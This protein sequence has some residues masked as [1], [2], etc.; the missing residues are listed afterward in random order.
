[1][2]QDLVNASIVHVDGTTVL[3]FT[4]ARSFLTQFAN[5]GTGVNFIYSHG[6][7]DTST[8]FGYHGSR[9]GKVFISDFIDGSSITPVQP[10]LP[11]AVAASAKSV[12]WIPKTGSLLT[13]SYI[14]GTN[15]VFVEFSVELQ[16]WTRAPPI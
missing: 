9:R 3:S 15:D 2:G 1:M 6:E 8:S 16:V 5:G 11:P 12:K 7:P 10:E 13:L 4:V 14:N